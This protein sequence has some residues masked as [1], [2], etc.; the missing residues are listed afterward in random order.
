MFNGLAEG[1]IVVLPSHGCNVRVGK[2]KIGAEKNTENNRIINQMLQEIETDGAV[3]FGENL[4][5][6]KDLFER[7]LAIAQSKNQVKK[8]V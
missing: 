1:L 8:E 4:I 5:K 3:I 2:W 7:L 6:A